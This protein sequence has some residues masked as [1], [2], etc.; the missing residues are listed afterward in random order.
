MKTI[1]IAGAKGGTGKTTTAIAVSYELARAGYRVTIAD[2]DP[3]A[4]AT[5]G[6]RQSPTDAPLA[7]E[8]TQLEFDFRSSW[9]G[10]ST[11][12]LHLARGGRSLATASRADVGDHLRRLATAVDFLVVDTSA[13]M[14]PP[15]LAAIEAADLIVVSLHAAPYCLSGLRDMLQTVTQINASARIRALLTQVKGRRRMVEYIATAVEAR[16]PALLYE[17]RVPHDAQCE[18]ASGECVPVGRFDARSRAAVAYHTLAHAMRSD[19]GLPVFDRLIDWEATR[20][21]SMAKAQ[22][23]PSTNGVAHAS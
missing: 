19:L 13:T 23:A 4:M 3:Q 2:C 6:L 12:A 8:P 5:Q 16:Y 7:T 1:T 11:G 14:A 20:K 18:S 10:R 15:L 17:T 22:S 9:N 21:R